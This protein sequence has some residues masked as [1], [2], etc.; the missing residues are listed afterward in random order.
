MERLWLE[1]PPSKETL[2]HCA[3]ATS[4]VGEVA[5]GAEERM[6]LNAAFISKILFCVSTMETSGAK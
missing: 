2:P 6:R 4:R 3:L 1:M 5:L